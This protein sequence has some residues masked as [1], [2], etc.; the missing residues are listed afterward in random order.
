MKQIAGLERQRTWI[1]DYSA[2]R[3]RAIDWLG[4]RYL[5]A[6]PINV[7]A[8]RRNPPLYLTAQASLR[9]DAQ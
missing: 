1:V 9:S 3:A 2:A 4:E 7:P 6:R 8:A 5:L